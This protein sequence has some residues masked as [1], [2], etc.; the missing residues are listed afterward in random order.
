MPNPLIPFNR[1]CFEGNEQAYIAQAIANGHIS[2][3]GAFSRKCHAL[4]QEQLGVP[5]VLLTTSCTH[6]LEMAAHL[7]DIQPGDE[8]IVPSFTFVST[9]NAFVLRGARPVFIDI[10]P[11]TLNLDETQ[12]ERL[13][14]PRT[15]AIVPVHY[16]GVGCEM[17]AIMEIARRHHIPVVEDN[18]HG[19]FGKYRGKYLGTFGALATQSFHETKNFT[20]GEGGALLIN[21]LQYAE[22]A[23]ILRE[24]GTN[25][26]RFFRGQVDKYTWVDIGS[27]YLPSDLLAAF[28]LAQLEQREN[29]Q[30]KRRALWQLYRSL[31]AEWAEQNLVRLPVVPPHC[32]QAYH[33]FYLLMPDLA[34]R[35]RFLAHLKERAILAVFHYLPLHRSP[36]AARWLDRPCV[37]PV[38]EEIS[39][40]L[41]RLP[42]FNSMTPEEILRV[43]AAVREFRCSDML[44]R[45]Q[46]PRATRKPAKV[47]GTT[48]VALEGMPQP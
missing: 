44:P 41:V 40:R 2:G 3:D 8:V 26:S 25:R 19:L 39:D 48:T 12:L 21:D 14:T 20:C 1:P 16:A 30:N 15:R 31:L 10:R 17:D 9:V 27:S 22:R 36:M 35:T 43:V 6:A 18:A 32:E 47:R 33:M 34:T 7:L 38:T 42:F 24:K 45:H 28:L 11:D 4:L 29:I 37:C 13:I 23:E 5:K 46:T